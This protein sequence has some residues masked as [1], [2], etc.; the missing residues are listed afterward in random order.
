MQAAPLPENEAQR[1][2]TLRLYEV[3]DSEPEQVFDDITE[4]SARIFETPICLVSFVDEKRQWFKSSVGLDV[5]E[6]GRDIA[7]CSHAILGDETFVV[8]DAKYDHRFAD[9]PLVEGDPKIRFYAGAPLTAADDSKLGTLCI[10][11]TT[12]RA[13][14][15]DRLQIL[16]VLRDAVVANLELRRLARQA[17]KPQELIAVCAWCNRIR[18]A[19]SQRWLHPDEYLQSRNEVTHSI[20]E[21]CRDKVMTS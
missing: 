13:I 9:N 20:C 1:L 8:E 18:D 12:P 2:Q 6:T 14:D 10:I 3:L 4:A 7:F 15:P 16:S 21:K 5:N 11:D 17:N 19:E